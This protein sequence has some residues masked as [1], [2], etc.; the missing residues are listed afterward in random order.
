MP[1]VPDG[2]IERSE[3]RHRAVVLLS[4]GL[5]SAVALG[6][7]LEAGHSVAV[8]LTADYGQ[9]SA[10]PEARAARALAAR[11]G[12]PWQR[13]PLPFL[14]AA[15]QA[16][17][18]ALVDRGVDVPQGTADCPGTETTARAVWVP[19]R[20]VVLVAAA[21]A[22]AEASGAGV[23]LLGL[24]REEAETFPDNSQGFLD[25]CSLVLGMG[26]RTGVRAESPTVGLDKRELGRE[27]RRLGL[28]PAELWS[29]YGA[30][31]DR[32]GAC[33]SCLRSRRAFGG[34][35]AAS[36]EDPAGSGNSG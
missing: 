6:L 20:N 13:L 25:A 12:V 3:A 19:A 4:G 16:A 30:G 24:N 22:A 8:C 7:W 11:L 36:G 26:T 15:A 5:D 31:P 33:E 29:C 28:D 32:C 23:V 34:P 2:A 35:P 14:A 1:L 17:G 9:R 21:A 18:S 27:A 10:A